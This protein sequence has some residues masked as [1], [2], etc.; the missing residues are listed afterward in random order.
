MKGSVLASD[1]L[2][3]VVRVDLDGEQIQIAATGH[4]TSSSL[5][6]LYPI[7]QR[8]SRLADG[9]G[10]EVDLSRALVDPDALEQLE[11]YARIHELPVRV[12]Y[13]PADDT[14]AILPSR[15]G[16]PRTL[17]AGRAA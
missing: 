1:R 12:E 6:G 10:I 13:A 15:I 2:S 7:V 16:D 5:Q 8:T 14:V 9:L 17:G 11:G 3:V 4:V